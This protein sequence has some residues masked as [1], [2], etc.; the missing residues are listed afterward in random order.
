M[1]QIIEKKVLSS[2]GVHQLRGKV[3]IPDGDIKGLFQVVHGM[4]EHIARYHDFLYTLAE[5]GYL[6]FAY[7]QLGHGH[8]AVDKSELGFIAHENGWK[9]LVDDVALFAEEIK[10]EYG[11]GLPYIL[12]GHSMGSFIAR[13][14]A[15]KFNLHDKLIIMGTGGP[16]PAVG[17]G[18]ATVK[19]IKKAKGE[20]HLSNLIEK[21]VFGAYNKKFGDD[22]RYNWLSTI[23]KTRVDYA[24]DPLCTFRFTVSAMGDLLNLTKES[25]SKRWFGSSVT[26]KPILLI[27]G[28]DDPVGNYGR[29]VKA[30]HDRLKANGADIKFKLYANC[31]H[32]ILNDICGKKVVKDILEFA[33][34]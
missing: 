31:R 9:L 12:M 22:D 8:T 23:E 13:L 26:E 24:N 21:L 27:S 1:I 5:N 14:A 7:D 6:A 28:A 10:Q 11:E 29:G 17:A 20:R 25:N 30:V 15:E 4:T 3:Y 2:D 16:N 32:E 18:L 19:I 34:K 33:A